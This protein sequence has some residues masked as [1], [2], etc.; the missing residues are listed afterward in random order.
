MPFDQLVETCETIG[1]A[2]TGTAEHIAA[3]IH[4][5]YQDLAANDDAIQRASVRHHPYSQA[6]PALSSTL[7]GHPPLSS[8]ANT[9]NWQD[10]M[11]D[12]AAINQ[13]FQQQGLQSTNLPGG[14]VS[15]LFSLPPVPPSIP[16]TPAPPGLHLGGAIHGVNNVG[17]NQAGL[18]L[19]IGT[20]NTP[21]V[22]PPVLN[23]GQFANPGLQGVSPPVL[24]YP[25][26]QQPPLS[27]NNPDL[28]TIMNSLTASISSSI[29]AAL[30]GL[31]GNTQGGSSGLGAG[32]GLG[33]SSGS[34][35]AGSS[36]LGLASGSGSGS[37]AGVAP[38]SGSGLGSGA[39]LGS[40]VSA[41]TGGP[42]QVQC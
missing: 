14:L 12:N 15:S 28:S 33:G 18:T 11:R 19:P 17:A 5:Y 30:S 1:I 8:Q 4:A 24:Q 25:T 40:G 39:G 36:G 21:I 37:G 31:Q 23:H 7:G 2:S 16:P 20:L 38:A 34:G 6:P 42:V 41:S 35:S 29:M 10:V 27:N 26:Q 32:V 9:I 13:Q 3:R 22:T